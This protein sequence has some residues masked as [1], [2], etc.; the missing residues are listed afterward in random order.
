MSSSGDTARAH[1]KQCGEV[2]EKLKASNASVEEIK[3]A[4]GA[5]QLA[6]EAL[7]VIV[8]G[9]RGAESECFCMVLTC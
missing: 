5:L 9:E 4:V 7:Q 3:R 6:K 1:V 8:Q 2:V